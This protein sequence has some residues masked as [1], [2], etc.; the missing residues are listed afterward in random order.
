M[1]RVVKYTNEFKSELKKLSRKYP[2][3]QQEIE[4]TLDD[5]ANNRIASGDKI[6]NVRGNPVFKIRIRIGNMGKRKGGRIIYYKDDKELYAL[7]LYPKNARVNIESEKI[8]RM[9]KK[10]IL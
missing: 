6:R 3:I 8:V 7:V 9:L 4:C 10:Y 2:G 1:V 5:L